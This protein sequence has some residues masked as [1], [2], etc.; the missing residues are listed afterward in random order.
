M[1][2]QMITNG[3]KAFDMRTL[4]FIY[5]MVVYI[6]AYVLAV[7]WFQTRKRFRGIS[8]FV[9]YFSLI[10]LGITL[11]LFRGALPDVLT[12]VAANGLMFAGHLSFLQGMARFLGVGLNIRPYLILG[13]TFIALYSWF[14]LVDP[15]I[16]MRIIIFSGFV[17]PS[18]VH[19]V[20]LIFGKA[21]ADHRNYA[22][23]AGATLTLFI[24]V[25]LLRIYYGVTGPAPDTYFTTPMPDSFFHLLGLGLTI[26]LTLSLHLMINA[27]LIHQAERHALEQEELASRDGLTGLYNRRKMSTLL[28]KE[29]YRFRR[30]GRP[31]SVILCDIDYFKRV[32]DTL[33]HDAGDRV[34]LSVAATLDRNIR[35]G[36]AAGRWGGE[37]FLLLLP[38]TIEA[39]AVET[40]E[41][42]RNQNLDRQPFER[43]GQSPVTISF[44]VAQC[45]PGLDLTRILKHA[46]QALYHAKAGGRNR[47][48]SHSR[49]LN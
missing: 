1:T 28:E 7:T 47:V 33:G 41:K 17:L 13:I 42:L 40:A 20:Y 11:S 35:S 34:L 16:R 18:L 3:L 43:E 38:E 22:F 14:S 39:K 26:L 9:L 37:E 49:I 4:V 44:G 29:L 19:S 8:G 31:F 24:P 23:N 10:A 32:N 12:V 45:R 6:A 27:K 36:D 30:Y 21:D 46:D 48:E 25:Y 2:I 15:E 5:L